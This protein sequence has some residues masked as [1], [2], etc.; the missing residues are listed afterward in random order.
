MTSFR[1]PLMSILSILDNFRRCQH[2]I[3]TITWK[4]LHKTI[5]KIFFLILWKVKILKTIFS[6]ILKQFPPKFS[7]ILALYDIIL[8]PKISTFWAFLTNLADFSLLLNYN[9]EI[10]KTN[11]GGYCLLYSGDYFETIFPTIFQYFGLMTSFWP[12]KQHFL[13]ILENLWQISAFYS[14]ITSKL[15][16]KNIEE[17]VYNT[18]VIILKHFYQN[19]SPFWPYDVISTPFN[20]YFEHFGQFSQMSAF[21]SN[22]NM[23][24]TP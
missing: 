9:M 6:K 17:T 4:S 14:T 2:F 16:P 21:Y 19:F 8:T 5:V 12:T 1:P 15:P 13:R 18:Q 7:T 20:E 3:Q 23:E 11:H 24:I 10:T 22:Y